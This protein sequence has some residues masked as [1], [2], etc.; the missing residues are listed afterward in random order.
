MKNKKQGLCADL[1]IFSHMLCFIS[2]FNLSCN[3]SILF[4]LMNDI[5][6][7]SKSSRLKELSALHLVFINLKLIRIMSKE[8]M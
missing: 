4:D 2:I 3:I 7:P 5:L 8:T 1:I 6:V